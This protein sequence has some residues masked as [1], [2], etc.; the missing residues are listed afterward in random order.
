MTSPEKTQQ[1][2]ESPQAPWSGKLRNAFYLTMAVSLW[3]ALLGALSTLTGSAEGKT[4]ITLLAAVAA[5]FTGAAGVAQ[6]KKDTGSTSLKTQLLLAITLILTVAAVL[7][8]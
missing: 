4:I 3:M 8:R 6:T 1:T 5:I 7:I 2:Q